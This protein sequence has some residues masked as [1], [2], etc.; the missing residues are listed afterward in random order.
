MRMVTA[1]DSRWRR[2]LPPP[3][4][5]ATLAVHRSAR[6]SFTATALSLALG[7]CGG[8]V[9][10]FEPTFPPILTFVGWDS[11][12]PGQCQGHL[13]NSG[14]TASDV[15][16]QLFYA[17][18]SGEAPLTVSI[19]G[20]VGPS[21]F[22]GASFVAAAQMTAGHQRFPRVGVITFANEKGSSR[23][24]TPAQP[25]A[26]RLSFPMPWCRVGTDSVQGEMQ[27]DGGYAYDLVIHV[28]TRDGLRDLV[29]N[30]NPLRPG[31]FPFNSL[32][33]DSAG[34]SVPPRVIGVHWEDYGGTR[35]DL[36]SP[37]TTGGISD[38]GQPW[39]TF[40]SGVGQF[41]DP[42]GVA[43]S[44]SGIVYVVDSGNNRI[45]TFTSDGIFIAQWGT[46]GIGDGEFNFGAWPL[47]GAAVDDSGNVYVT[48]T[49]N[50][51]IQKFT[52]SGVY[53]TQWGTSRTADGQYQR[54]A[55]VAVDAGGN[56]YVTDYYN[57]RVKVFNSSGAYVR[58]WGMDG[59][60]AG[61]AVDAAGNVCVAD[62]RGSR[63]FT[64][65]S[66]GTLLTQFG[67]VGTG[68][69]EFSG[70]VGVALDARGDI[71]VTDYNNNRIEAFTSGGAYVHQ[72]GASGSP[73]GQLAGPRGV[74]VDGAGNIFVADTNKH[75]ILKFTQPSTVT[76]LVTRVISK[77]PQMR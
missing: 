59:A 7:G 48:D 37:P 39:G 11:I 21:P 51:R 45:Q 60:P 67:T 74:A 64:F 77:S 41:N 76:S 50:E 3:M 27:N 46:K 71:Y 44:A 70:P 34:V 42:S 69:G 8:G 55:G 49:L 47:A 6:W 66:S 5:R 33:G 75:R 43:V 20:L 17:T 19:P 2:W 54:P 14:F 12:A 28:Q 72:W 68:D 36:V 16:V 23:G 35:G 61:V 9:G 40:G 26:P 13:Y 25:R 10:G 15:R 24:S 63:I 29:L 4:V 18:P 1:F 57:G 58:Q 62:F 31:R 56:V 52:G 22:G 30:R 53:V 38:C 32:V 73:I 65:T